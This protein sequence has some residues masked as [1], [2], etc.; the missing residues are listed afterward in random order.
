MS[1]RDSL[2]ARRDYLTADGKRPSKPQ[3][4]EIRSKGNLYLT[5][6]SN[7]PNSR[8]CIFKSLQL[9]HFAV[10]LRYNE[11]PARAWHNE[12]S[13]CS[14]T[15]TYAE[16]VGKIWSLHVPRLPGEKRIATPSAGMSA[17]ALVA[18]LSCPR[19]NQKKHE[20]GSRHALLRADRGQ[21]HLAVV[22]R[23]LTFAADITVTGVVRRRSE[24]RA[25]GTFMSRAVR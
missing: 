7:S 3:F 24:W 19:G 25:R 5:K 10:Q 2:Q 14:V 17:P 4:N 15:A 22:C 1:W 8:L 12:N 23:A 13:T 20:S 18:F 11:V 21:R 6:F 9:D 16:V